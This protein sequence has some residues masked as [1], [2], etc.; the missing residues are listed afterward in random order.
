MAWQWKER[1]RAVGHPVRISF[2]VPAYNEEAYI[3][4][5]LEAIIAEL[6]RTPCKAELIVVD[7]ASTD[8]T[9]EVA[10]TY[11]GVLVVAEPV[12]GLVRA[13]A[14]GCR[15]ATGRL[16][17]NI[18][19]DTILPEGW[20]GRVLSEFSA[21]PA[22]VALSGPCIYYDVPKRVSALV[23]LFY[24]GGFFFY[25]LNRYVLHAGSMLQGGNFVVSRDGLAAIGGFNPAFTFWGEDTDLARRLSK[26][27][28]VKFTFS[29]PALSSGRRL[30]REG[31]VRTGVRYAVNFFWATFLRKP[32]THD[33]IDV[34]VAQSVTTEADLHKAESF[35]Q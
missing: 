23:T 2:V 11:R 31:V 17:A 9:A 33:W 19:A 24:G 12:K 27:G 30:L 5:C 20:L 25:L 8:R 26:I 18:D 21:D 22:L 32:Y 13:R 34:R 29:L 14:A 7:N 28:H 15:A 16:I 10:R 35:D 1:L 6:E 3:A 4:R